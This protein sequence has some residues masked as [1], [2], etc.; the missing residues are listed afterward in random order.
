[1]CLIES[2]VDSSPTGVKDSDADFV[3]GVREATLMARFADTCIGGQTSILTFTFH[4]CF[5]FS[6]GKRNEKET[7]SSSFGN[8]HV[9]STDFGHSNVAECELWYVLALQKLHSVLVLGSNTE[10]QNRQLTMG[11]GLSLTRE[12]SMEA[13]SKSIPRSS[14]SYGDDS[15]P[16][17]SPRDACEAC[18][19]R[20]HTANSSYCPRNHFITLS[21]NTQILRR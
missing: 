9:L 2:P 1:M 5:A 7:I 10:R 21:D 20:C 16:S 6:P 19:R 17:L 3:K 18:G 12:S 13:W 8:I 15:S 14:H 11:A 4:P